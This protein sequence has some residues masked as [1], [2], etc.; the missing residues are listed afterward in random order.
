MAWSIAGRNARAEATA[1]LIVE[2]S[3]HTDDPGADGTANEVSGGGY[4]RQSPQFGS[5]SDGTVGLTEPMEF[6]GPGETS[7]EYAGL[8]G[9]G[10]AFLGAVG[11][12]GG[13]GAFNAAGEYSVSQFNVTADGSITSA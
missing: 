8:W 4:S 12:A 6:S 9:D 7:V 13:D 11:R 10:G 2:V 3:L 1:G 5:A